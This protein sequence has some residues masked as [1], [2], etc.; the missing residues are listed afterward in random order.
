MKRTPPSVPGNRLP[1]HDVVLSVRSRTP[2]TAVIMAS[3]KMKVP[4][5]VIVGLMKHRSDQ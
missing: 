5:K 2:G 4:M 1:T 3:M